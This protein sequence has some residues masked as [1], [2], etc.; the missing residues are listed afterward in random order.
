M[1]SPFPSEAEGRCRASCN[2]CQDHDS[3]LNSELLSRN[4]GPWRGVTDPGGEGATWEGPGEASS[5]LL[6]GSRWGSHRGSED[7][8]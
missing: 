4:C 5:H 3:G 1:H 8:P 6:A 2:A 7:C